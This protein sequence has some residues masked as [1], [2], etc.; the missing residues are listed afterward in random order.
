LVKAQVKSIP[1]LARAAS[2]AYQTEPQPSKARLIS[3]WGGSSWLIKLRF[4][5]AF[6]EYEIIVKINKN[7]IPIFIYSI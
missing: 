7:F 6:A 4:L 2:E 1:S 3:A 5:C